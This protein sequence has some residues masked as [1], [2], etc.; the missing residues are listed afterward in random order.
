M[1]GYSTAARLAVVEA[2]AKELPDYL[3]NDGLYRNLRVDTPEGS[4]APTLTPGALLEN[5]ALLRRPDAG[6]NAEQQARLAAVQQQADQARRIYA[7]QWRARAQRELKAALDSWKWYLDDAQGSARARE[8]YRSEVHLR[9][10]IATLLAELG[11]DPATA[12]A[13]RRLEVLDAHLRAMLQGSAYVGPPGA[14][15][16]YPRDR[17]WWLYGRP[18]GTDEE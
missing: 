8:N 10:R 18:G 14:E 17:G 12:D 1:E 3:M 13:R 5:L 4:V 6:L 11:D 9:T 16:L 7:E 15:S 2:M